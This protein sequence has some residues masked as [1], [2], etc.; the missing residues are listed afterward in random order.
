MRFGTISLTHAPFEDLVGRWRWFE[1]L[2]FDSAWLDDDFVGNPSVSDY[3]A[4]TVLGALARETSRMRIGTLV[5]AIT[6]RHPTFLAA[7]VVSVD[8]ISGGRVTLGLGSGAVNPEFNQRVGQG[9]WTPAERADRFEE[10]VVILDTLLRG[11]PI[12]HGGPHYPTVVSAMPPPVQR[13]RPPILLAAHGPRGLRL[14]ARYADAWNCFGGQLYDGPDR[15]FAEAVADT[16]RLIGRLDEACAEVGRDPATLDRSIYAF[17][18]TPDPFSSLDW[19]DEY[20]GAYAEV[21][22][23]EIL[24]LWPPDDYVYAGAEPVPAERVRTF[25]RIAA[26]RIGHR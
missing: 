23:S 26:D 22:I 21:G 18:A 25:E 13:P 8:Q 24:F 17:G 16:R 14:A 6:F 4:W 7:Q 15:P 11:E 20:V 10:Q 1:S 12:S 5:S 3:E 9:A 2:G 19:F